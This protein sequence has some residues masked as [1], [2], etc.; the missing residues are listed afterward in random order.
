M[1]E[2]EVQLIDTLSR[3]RHAKTPDSDTQD[4]LHVS[5]RTV[6]RLNGKEGTVE[7]L[8][9]QARM[10][11]PGKN[12][13]VHPSANKFPTELKTLRKD[14][15][16]RSLSLTS[17][18]FLPTGEE[19]TDFLTVAEKIE[20]VSRPRL[21]HK[22]NAFHARTGFKLQ[23]LPDITTVRYVNDKQEV[24]FR[25]PGA[26]ED[27]PMKAGR[28]ITLVDLPHVHTVGDLRKALEGTCEFPE[29]AFLQ[30]S[31]SNGGTRFLQHEHDV[32]CLCALGLQGPVLTAQ[33]FQGMKLNVKSLTGKTITIYMHPHDTVDD[34]KIRIQHQEGIPLDQQRLIF[35]GMQLEDGRTLGDY[36]IQHE[37]C[38]HLLMRLR[39][40]M[41][42]PTSARENFLDLE[43]QGKTTP[44]L[45][46][47]PDGKEETIEVHPNLSLEKVPAVAYKIAKSKAI[48]D[49]I[50]RLKAE[51]EEAKGEKV[52]LDN[53]H[54]SLTSCKEEE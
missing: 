46:L 34:C 19:V 44:L 35:A 51:L 17:V 30:L 37:S 12:L 3:K 6:V 41:Y 24:W 14:Q 39:G 40:G 11:F 22:V 43:G 29:N 42:D 38:L 45:V 48:D 33:P 1:L 18:L 21:F 49:R 20:E 9:Q 52:K 25:L 50:K 32:D 16:V 7:N 54:A 28:K 47:F 2:I 10:R 13:Q 15:P 8:L 27:V 36:N 5:E 31:S 23:V 53:E 26:T 4:S